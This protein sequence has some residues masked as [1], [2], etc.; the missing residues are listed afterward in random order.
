VGLLNRRLC[1]L[2]KIYA[3][4]HVSTCAAFVWAVPNKEKPVQALDPVTERQRPVTIA[5]T[6]EMTEFGDQGY[7]NGLSARNKVALFSPDGGRFVIVVKKGNLARS[8]NDYSLLL[9]RTAQALQSPPP[10]LLASFSSS[11]NRPAIQQMTWLDNH[12]IAFLGENPGGMQQLYTVDC[13]TSEVTKLTNHSTG[14]ASY[15]ISPDH[16]EVFYTSGKPRESLIN[17]RIERLGFV[18][19]SQPLADLVSGENHSVSEDTQDLLTKRVGSDE[20]TQI[21]TNGV[22]LDSPLWLSPNGRYLILETMVTDVPE[23]WSEYVEPNFGLSSAS[24]RFRGTRSYIFRYELVDTLSHQDRVLLDAPL[25]AWYRGVLWSPNSDSVVISGTYLPLNAPNSSEREARR[26]HLFVAEIKIPSLEV[27]PITD[28][29]SKLQRWDPRNSTILL[30]STSKS[31]SA[32]RTGEIN[33]YQKTGSGWK[34]VEVS[35]ADLNEGG[36]VEITLEEDMNTSP[37][38]FAKDVGTEQKA[39]LLD[40][41]PQFEQRRFSRVEEITFKATDGHT[42]RGGLYRPPSYVPGIRYPL[43]LQTHGWNPERFWIDGP[44]TTAFAAQ[45]L[46]S[47]GLVVLQLEEDFTTL[48]TSREAPEE[49]AAYEGAIDYVAKLGLVDRDRVGVIGFSRSGFTVQYTLTHSKYHFAAATIADGSGS[50]YFSYLAYGNASTT[51]FTD[52]EHTN[53]GLPF[54]AGLASWLKNSTGFT[55]DRVGAAVRLEANGPMSLFGPWEWF[56]GLSRLGKPVELVYLPE[57]VHVLVKPWERMT[58]Q[59]G[60]VDWFC[61]WLK[62]EEDPDPAKTE[63]YARW[64]ELRRLQQEN[65]A[66]AKASPVN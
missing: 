47:K 38:L 21:Q 46:A 26:A 27:V 8:T 15:A 63:Q 62:G 17:E 33:G 1:Q 59:Q 66:K 16:G 29:E 52:Y 45:A 51:L 57:A 42:V 20:E 48:G 22:I 4:V 44:Y 25:R 40:L 50:G 2:L 31:A 39:L 54:G 60:N 32:D 65:Q 18:V 3:L 37:K 58:S 28:Q 41:N 14:L 7:M 61:F 49:M 23:T 30:E 56:V 12:T 13:N 24:K 5:D 64:R 34:K 19:G 53:G 43:I 55:L 11:S 6:I 10:Q 9:F 35:G 36:L